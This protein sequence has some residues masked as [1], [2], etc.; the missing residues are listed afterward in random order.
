MSVLDPKNVGDSVRFSLDACTVAGADLA[1]SYRHADP[2]PNIVLDDFL[3]LNLCRRVVN[4]FPSRIDG[5]HSD[6]HSQ[7]KTG[8]ELEQIESA[9]T[10][11]L[12]WAFNS[13]EFLQFL[14]S[15]T[16]IEGLMGDPYFDGGGLHETSRGG[17]LSIHADFNVHRRLVLHRRINLILFLNDDWHDDYGGSLE[18]WTRDMKEMH[19]QVSPVIGRAV[20]FN[21]DDSSYHG[22]PDPLT[23]PDSRYRR[24]L[25]LYY[26]TSPESD[27]LETRR[28]TQ[29]KRRPR[30]EDSYAIGTALRELWVDVC[31]PILRRPIAKLVGRSGDTR[32]T[33]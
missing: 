6:K 25:A 12:L 10:T 24:S 21:T 5:R 4:E 16:G 8:Y 27:I 13:A 26:Y 11:N 9:F 30:S 31:P 18:L 15:M 22:H 28:T 20:I 2:F 7:L 19:T 32:K 3:P 17:H 1:D 33:G 23:C 14:E 29:F